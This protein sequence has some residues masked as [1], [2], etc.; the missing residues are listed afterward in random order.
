MPRLNQIVAI[1][2]DLQKQA[3]ETTKQHRTVLEHP[4]LLHGLTRTYHPKGDQDDKLPGEFSRVQARIPDLLDSLSAH[5]TQV[6]DNAATLDYTNCTAKADVVVDG[7][8][9]L[10]QVPP[11][12]L[13]WLA[14]QLGELEEFLKRIPTLDPTEDWTF[15][16][17]VGLW[18]TEAAETVRTKKTPRTHIKYEATAQHPA[19]VEMYYEDIPAGN[20]RVV[21]T[22]GAVPVTRVAEL[23]GRIRK[24][25]MAVKAAREEANTVKVEEHKA[26]EAIFGYLL[27]P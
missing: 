7:V 11:T 23:L 24:L 1:Q 18:K 17:E 4:Q 14:R 15:D 12:Y 10:E 25:Q 2:A 3:V 8:K 26:G 19:Q 5:L 21:K 13:L 6:F 22:S 27:A 16:A 9:V 20:W